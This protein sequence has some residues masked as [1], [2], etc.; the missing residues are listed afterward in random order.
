MEGEWVYEQGR[1][2]ELI[3]NFYSNLY[4]DSMPY[5]PCLEGVEFDRIDGVQRDWLERPFSEEEI[6]SA[7]SS[8]EDSKALMPDGFPPIFLKVCWKVVAKDV[9]AVFQTFHS[10]NQWCKSLSVTFI[11]LIPKKNGAVHIK[12][13]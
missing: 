3:E 11:T 7:L 5:R 6:K 8:M 9:L 13:F 10:W 12:Y 2:R 4:L 1:I